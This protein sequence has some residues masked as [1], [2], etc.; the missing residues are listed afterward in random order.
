MFQPASFGV[1]EIVVGTLTE[2]ADTLVRDHGLAFKSAHGIASRL[3]GGRHR[4]PQRPLVA[5]LADASRD[6]LGEPIAYSE[7]ALAEVLSARHFV[8]VRKT[9]GGPAPEETQR[10]ANASRQQLDA[11]RAWWDHATNALA[12]AERHLAARSAAL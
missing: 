2:L 8:N 6:V 9:P 12:E 1:L 10:A 11:D 7:E 4:D 5:L 3:I